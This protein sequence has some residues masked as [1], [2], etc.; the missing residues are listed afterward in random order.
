M[1]D[2]THLLVGRAGRADF[3][4]PVD[5]SGVSVDDGYV[6]MLGNIHAQCRLSDCSRPRDDYQ[7]LFQMNRLSDDAALGILDE[8]TDVLHLLAV[9]E[10]FASH[11]DTVFQYTL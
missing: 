4:F 3:Q 7:C 11:S 8:R 9:G 6:E 10:L 1:L 2:F 5:L